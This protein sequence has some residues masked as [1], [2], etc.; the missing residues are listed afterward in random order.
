MICPTCGQHTGEKRSEQSHR[1]FRVWN[2]IIAQECGHTEEEMMCVFFQELGYGEMKEAVNPF[3]GE[4]T[5]KFR[6]RSTRTLT[7]EEMKSLMD[8]MD[9]V[10]AEHEY[11]LPRAA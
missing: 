7:K 5:E 9:R 1:L 4:V 6:R 2:R 11:R 10:G 3:T 8:L